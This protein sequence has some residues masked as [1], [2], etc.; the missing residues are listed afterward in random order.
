MSTRW[1]SYWICWTC[2]C[3]RGAGCQAPR[4]SCRVFVVS[5][6]RE[7]QRRLAEWL[8]QLCPRWSQPS[9]GSAPTSHFSAQNNG[10]FFFPPLSIIFRS[11]SS[12]PNTSLLLIRTKHLPFHETNVRLEKTQNLPE[13][14]L[15]WLSS[16]EARLFS[17]GL[18]L[19]RWGT[20]P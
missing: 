14:L 3:V 12:N 8:D 4:S 2:W 16:G 18:N 15:I 1:S 17:L 7:T 11:L 19:T 20:V 5:Q 6:K 10:L 9:A 13:H